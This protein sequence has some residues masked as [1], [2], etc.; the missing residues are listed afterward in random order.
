MDSVLDWPF[1]FIIVLWGERFCDYFLEYCVPSMLSP[2]NLPAL[3]TSQPSKFLIATTAADWAALQ[4]SPV[5]S[6]MAHYIS[7]EIIEI[8]PCPPGRSSYDHMGLGHK[9][10]CERAFRNCAYAM[11]LTPDCMLSDGTISRLQELAHAGCE[12][13]VAAAIRFSEE[14]FLGHLRKLGVLPE[15]PSSTTAL[16]LVITGRQMA[17][18]AVNG[19]HNEALAYEWDVPGFLV[20]VPAAWWRVPGEDGIVLHS[21]TWAPMLLD[22]GAIRVHDM[23]TLDQW[24]LDGDYLFNNAKGMTKIHVVQDS[25][26]LFLASWGPVDPDQVYK[27]RFPLFGK[28]GAKAQFGASFRSAFFDP[29]KRRIFFLPVRWHAEPLNR[30]WEGIED[31]ATRELLRYATP[32]GESLFFGTKNRVEKLHRLATRALTTSFIILRPLFIVIYYPR[33]IWQKLRQAARGDPA[34]IRQLF[35]YFRLFGFNRY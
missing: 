13:V 2:G 22:Y 5:F 8:P 32:P 35:W 19:L 31:R 12:L 23:S 14:A 29:F 27:H 30:T 28:L 16:P 34:S 20:V 25:D 3:S 11:V 9:L 10:A 33:K 15:A 4:S 7:A 24:T 26:E 21:L 6:A 1:Y 17:Y 18:A